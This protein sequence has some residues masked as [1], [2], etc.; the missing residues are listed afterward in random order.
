MKLI[1]NKIDNKVDKLIKKIYLIYIFIITI[2]VYNDQTYNNYKFKKNL[3]SLLLKIQNK[4][5]ILTFVII[6]NL[7]KVYL[8]YI[9]KILIFKSIIFN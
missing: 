1:D 9:T 7:L 3:K 4:K 6:K 2:I 5:L 8:Y